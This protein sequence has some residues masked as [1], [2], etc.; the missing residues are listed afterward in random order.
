MIFRTTFVLRLSLRYL[1]PVSHWVIP[2]RRW[3]V[4]HGSLVCFLRQN[5]IA[6]YYKGTR[7][8]ATIQFF[9]IFLVLEEEEAKTFKPQQNVSFSA[10]SL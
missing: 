6:N 2:L 4:S 5:T 7:I 8:G 3:Q 9:F 1:T 10:E